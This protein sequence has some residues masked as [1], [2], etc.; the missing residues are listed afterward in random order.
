MNDGL[1][2]TTRRPTPAP[3][4]RS[5][6][7]VAALAG[8]SVGTVSNVLNRPDLVA[9]GTAE[10][11]RQAIEQ[12]GF[13]RNA[14]AR[15]LRAGDSRAV[16][17]VVLDLANPFFA[18]VARGIEDRLA[19]SGL[20]LA[21]C[22]S[23]G[24]AATERRQLELLE[25]QRVLGVLITPLTL[26]T[27]DIA[28][29]RRRGT[30]VV[31]LDREDSKNEMCSVAVDDVRG[32]ELAVSHLL[33]LGHRRIGFLNGP[34]SIRQCAERREGG[35]RAVR[36]AGLDP[37]AVIEEVTVRAL[38][39]DGGEKGLQELAAERLPS[40]VFCV[41]DLTALGVL[42]A[43]RAQGKAIPQ[44]AAVVGYDDVEF[45]A[46]LTTPLTSVRQPMYELGRAATELLLQEAADPS[47]CHEHIRFTPELVVRASS[48]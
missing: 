27:P 5:V 33:E 8:V 45:A 44:D 30:P 20:V 4:R 9:P 12:L 21:L 15:Q 22:S 25:E 46:M 13:V 41:N 16:G 2:A 28:A 38:N 10:R 34:L 40:A 42:R 43:L 35:L 17:A 29:L 31:L 3:R 1:E 32:G 7:D 18:E 11:V 47:H 14:S 6:R 26:D 36:K 23:H 39:A 19:E 24:S 48:C 37:A